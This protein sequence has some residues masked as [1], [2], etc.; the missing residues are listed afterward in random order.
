VERFRIVKIIETV[1]KNIEYRDKE[2]KVTIRCI[3]DENLPEYFET[4]RRRLQQIL[5]N[6]LSNAQ[7]FSKPGGI[8]TLTVSFSRY[9]S[10]ESGRT[11]ELFL[12]VKDH[13]KGIS[14]DDM[15]HVFEPLTQVAAHADEL[16]AGTGLG[17]AITRKL[18]SHLGGR[19]T[20]DS[21]LGLWTEFVVHFPVVEET[22]RSSKAMHPIALSP[23][24]ET[25]IP[26]DNS[27]CLV[28]DPG[29]EVPFE[30][31]Q[32]L[33]ADDNI[34]NRKLLRK[35][36]MS[37]GVRHVNL[38]DAKDG[39]EAVDMTHE[40]QYDIVFMDVDMPRLNGID[41]TRIIKGRQLDDGCAPPPKIFFVTAHSLRSYESEA[42]ESGGDGYIIKPYAKGSLQRALRSVRRVDTVLNKC[43]LP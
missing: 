30:V 33:S 11:G 7:K 19:V 38:A 23:I 5:Y 37:L 32:V 35:I 16:Y 1:A 36:L 22:F 31:L 41:A 4:D 26:S 13:G 10:D 15:E 3:C 29:Q 24:D 8:V 27:D 21:E 2:K 9:E 39:Q 34:I 17:L 28:A 12:A 43:T 14:K 20:V 40:R 18:V 25:S 6:L 42:A